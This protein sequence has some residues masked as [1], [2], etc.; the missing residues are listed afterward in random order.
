M[1]EGYID[2]VSYYRRTEMKYV[3]KKVKEHF[4]N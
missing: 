3:S 4:I 1:T 2:S